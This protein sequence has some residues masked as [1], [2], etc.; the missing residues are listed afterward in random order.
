VLNS[1]ELIM[2]VMAY[3]DGAESVDEVAEKI[4]F[5]KERIYELRRQLK[6][7]KQSAMEMLNSKTPKTHEQELQKG[8]RETRSLS[9]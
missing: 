5:T 9:S 3:E 2:I 6:E 1:D 7:M 4:G 8:V